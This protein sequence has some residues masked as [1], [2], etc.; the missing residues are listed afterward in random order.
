MSFRL[1]HAQNHK[2]NVS[3][4]IIEISSN[5]DSEPKAEEMKQKFQ[6]LEVSKKRTLSAPT[7]NPPSKRR[8]M[9]AEV[10]ELLDSDDDIP[11]IKAETLVT[12]PSTIPISSSPGL[13][14]RKQLEDLD[15]KTEQV[16]PISEEPKPQIKGESSLAR[17]TAI[18]PLGF[19]IDESAKDS[20]GRYIV[21]KKVKVDS[22]EGLSEVPKWWPVPPEDTTVAYVIDLNEDKRWQEGTSKEKALDQ[23][24]KQE[25]VFTHTAIEL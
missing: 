24:L 4:D 20:D 25:V 18:M 5:S 10:I 17:S 3:K 1:Q 9:E 13:R 21:T 14:S 19:R 6:S 16:P 2:S 8:L 7:N 12:L 23:F 15:I 22:V 11:P